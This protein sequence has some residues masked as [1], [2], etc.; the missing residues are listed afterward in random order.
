MGGNKLS[1]EMTE[2]QSLFAILSVDKVAACMMANVS[3]RA[4]R[5]YWSGENSPSVDKLNEIRQCA[6]VIADNGGV[7]SRVKRKM[8]REQIGPHMLDI[9]D[10]VLR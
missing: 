9:I 5:R 10:E 2:L 7:I 4:V 6:I 8:I 3:P 1:R